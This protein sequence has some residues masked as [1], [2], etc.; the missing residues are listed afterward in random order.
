MTSKPIF[1]TIFTIIFT[2]L[3]SFPAYLL[4][5]AVKTGLF[6]TDADTM[7][8]TILGVIM[9]CAPIVLSILCCIIRKRP[10]GLLSLA[11]AL[12]WVIIGAAM[13]EKTH[14][15]HVIVY[16]AMIVVPYILCLK[17]ILGEKTK[18]NPRPYESSYTIRPS[19]YSG[20][21]SGSMNFAEKD[22]Y[23]VHNN[24]GAFTLDGI[25]KIKNDPNLSASQKEELIHHMKY[26]GD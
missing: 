6:F 2:A 3:F 13:G 5:D 1:K 17:M 22:S 15:G 14:E 23:I 9:I 19:S 4:F 20:G 8:I 26:Y 11:N 21:T 24:Y 16:A 10:L 7:E 25:E 18:D 12:L